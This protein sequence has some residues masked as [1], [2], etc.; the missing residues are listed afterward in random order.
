MRSGARRPAITTP[1]ARTTRCPGSTGSWQATSPACWSSLAPSGHQMT[2]HDWKTPYA[3]AMMVF[4][5][6]D[7]ITEPG[8]HGER[9]RDESF[10]VLLSAHNE[11]LP[12]TLP[13]SAF[14]ESWA[15]VSDPAATDGSATG[16]GRAELRPGDE[17]ML[18]SNC[19]VVLR[20]SLPAAPQGPLTS[21]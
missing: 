16:E 20:R 8:P 2:D 12:F 3:R 15:V 5:N 10:L 1:T 14:G 4:L 11:P 7:A 19:L 21:Q 13:G 6:G 18:P 17:V 9:V